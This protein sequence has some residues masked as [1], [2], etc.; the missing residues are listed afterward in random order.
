MSLH[1]DLS[2]ARW[3]KASRSSASGS[4]CVELAH[5][6]GVIAVRDSKNPSGHKILLD[7]TA[8]R[9]LTDRMSRGELDL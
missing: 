5:A 7:R 4:D 2:K 1:D 8:W 6:A 3:R 9:Q